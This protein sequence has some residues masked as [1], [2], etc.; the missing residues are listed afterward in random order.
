[1][2]IRQ[3]L[4][5]LVA[6]MAAAFAQGQTASWSC[7]DN[8][9]QNGGFTNGVVVVGD[10]SIPTSSVANWT[11]AYRTPQIQR[12]NGCRDANYISMWGNRAVGEAITQPVSFQ[13][14]VTY[15]V[16]F[17]ARFQQGPVNYANVEFRASTSVPGDTSCAGPNCEVM[18]GAT[19]ITS[20]AWNTYR[21]CW[22]PK[23][24][25]SHL[26]ISTTNAIKVDDGSQVSWSNV[27]NICIQ[28]MQISGPVSS[29]VSP[30]TYCVTSPAAGYTYTWTVNGGSILGSNSG[31]CAVVNWNPPNAGT[32]TVTGTIP[33]GCAVSATQQVRECGH[34]NCCRDA[35]I[36][37]TQPI[38][39]AASAPNV[40]TITSQLTA[41]S[42][43]VTVKAT[44]LS[45]T[46][47]FNPA[48]CG[49]A[50]PIN[51]FGAPAQPAPPPS[52]TGPVLP[53]IGSHVAVWDAT[54]MSF[55]PLNAVPFASNVQLPPPPGSPLCTETITICVTYELTSNCCRTCSVTRCFSFTRK[56]GIPSEPV[57]VDVPP[58]NT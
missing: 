55:S 28:P 29:C 50:G 5:C 39:T 31:T 21:F 15:T 18:G 54:T 26:T 49:A 36:N 19:N 40:Y 58:P 45:A 57:P 10:G 37:A 24:N 44:L 43:P 25:Y 20:T 9:V 35:R 2:N 3:G 32:V 38:L 6:A 48:S 1:M 47:T 52:F 46:R 33:G 7:P 11:S 23:Q 56:G 16:E 27:D 8:V 30:S 14:N 13:A 17:C 12:T 41:P 42:L 22:T 51:V 4:L 34:D 53:V